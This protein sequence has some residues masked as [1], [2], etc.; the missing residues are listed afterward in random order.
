MKKTAV[1]LG[2]SV[3]VA[4]CASMA[5]GPQAIDWNKIP[6]TKVALFYPGQ[7]S[8]QWLRSEAHAGAA[9][10][11]ARGDACTSCHDDPKE[12]Q[13]QGAKILRGDHP[14]EPHAAVLKGKNGHIDMT[15]QAPTTTRTPTCAS[16]TRRITRT[17][18]A[19]TIRATA[20]TARNG[21]PTAACASTRTC[22]PA[23]PGS[24]MRT[25]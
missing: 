16:S 17:T 6:A 25:A 19:T 10:E 18:R 4:G 14:L 13:R 5:T 20:S 3:I 8:Y 24:S 2:V 15:V 1:F 22:W 21:K 11:T 7:S 23:R 12:E 9:K